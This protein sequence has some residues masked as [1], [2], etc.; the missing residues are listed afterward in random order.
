MT[1]RITKMKLERGDYDGIL[2][3]AIGIF[4]EEKQLDV[5]IEEMAELTKEIIKRKRGIENK[6]SLAEEIADVLIM[7]RQIAMIIDDDDLVDKL[8]NAKVCRLTG[9][10]TEWE[11]QN[12]K[13]GEHEDSN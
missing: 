8:I 7:T 12:F 9:R 3:K 2:R 10:L 11:F 4:G 6:Y 13:D 5:A 1:G